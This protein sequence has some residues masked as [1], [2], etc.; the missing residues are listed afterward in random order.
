MGKSLLVS[1]TD[2]PTGL[3]PEGTRSWDSDVVG[4]VTALPWK[5]FCRIPLGEASFL[6]SSQFLES[7]TISQVLRASLWQRELRPHTKLF[8]YQ[9]ADIFRFPVHCR[10]P[11][12]QKML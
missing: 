9:V 10:I 2:L 1:V 12:T 3:W 4:S 5:L 7:I 8:M 6:N 11:R